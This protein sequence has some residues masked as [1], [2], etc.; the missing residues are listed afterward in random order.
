MCPTFA[1]HPPTE[2]EPLAGP[3]DQLSRGDATLDL[4]ELGQFWTRIMGE[5]GTFAVHLLG[6]EEAALIEQA[7]A[8]A[9]N[10]RDLRAGG[11]RD[12]ATLFAAAEAIIHFKEATEAGI[13]A[14]QIQSIIHPALADHIRREA[15]KFHDELSRAAG[16]PGGVQVKP[17]ALPNTG[18]GSVPE[19]GAGESE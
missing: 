3:L 15:V 13:E 14:A 19:E 12:M 18:D 1:A 4:G 9:A 8:T 6:P 16:L 17:S 5:H 11:V 7:R 10:F 2:A